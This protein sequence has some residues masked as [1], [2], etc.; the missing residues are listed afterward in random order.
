MTFCLREKIIGMGWPV[1][2]AEFTRSDDLEQYKAAAAQTYQADTSWH[3][4]WTFAEEP[5]LHDLV[6]TRDKK[7]RYLLAEILSPWQY[8][9][10]TSEAI[11]ADIVNIRQARIIEI[12]FA[13]A[14]PSKIIA[15]FSPPKTFQII[16]FRGM[17]A[18]SEQLAGLP[19]SDDSQPDLYEFMSDADIENLIFM[20]LQVQD[21]FI[22]PG[23]RMA[24]TAFYEF[25]LIHRQTAERAIVQV[26]SGHTSIDA[27]AYE[28]TAKAFL[29]AAS[30]H[31]GSNIPA[32][33]VIIQRDE[34][35][36]FMQ[37]RPELLPAAVK[38]WIELVGLPKS[39][40]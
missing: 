31:Y 19:V 37:Q 25:V 8:V 9:Y 40:C 32:N 39:E 14:V 10:E 24:T 13:D 17:L 30:G 22:L 7:G 12:G 23:T 35:N 11:D 20:Y 2:H 3:S 26:K 21:W 29:F 34:L 1:A 27:S 33:A 15:C 18:F 6:W 4:V 36:A 38:T 28:G 16:N 5:A